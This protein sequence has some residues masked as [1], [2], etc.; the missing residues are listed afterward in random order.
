MASELHF[1]KR[2]LNMREKGFSLIEVLISL[3]IFSFT[4]ISLLNL[5]TTCFLI[6]RKSETNFLSSKIIMEKFEY[7][8]SVPFESEI[9]KQG[10][11]E[12]E[13]VL[14]SYRKTYIRRWKILDLSENLKRIEIQV[15]H[16]NQSAKKT[17]FVLYISKNLGF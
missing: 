2:E 7:L 17:E 6:K 11:Y 1:I 14:Q 10:I 5:V 15:W 8:K 12:E 16:K 9:L 3:F 4:L 13:V